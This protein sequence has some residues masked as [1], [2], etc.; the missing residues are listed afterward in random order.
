MK[1]IKAY[2]IANEVLSSISRPGELLP[3]GAGA[4][5][6]DFDGSYWVDNGEYVTNDLSKEGAAERIIQFLTAKK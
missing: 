2:K 1:A 4:T 3:I 5:G 6:I